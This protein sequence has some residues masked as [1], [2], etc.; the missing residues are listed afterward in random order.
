MAEPGAVAGAETQA[1][2][3]MRVEERQDR[4]VAILGPGP[5][6]A[7]LV[8]GD[9][10]LAG[11]AGRALRQHDLGRKRLAAAPDAQQEACRLQRKGPLAGRPHP[12]GRRPRHD[13][14]QI[15]RQAGRP[16]LRSS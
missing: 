9:L 14:G 8:V 4:E 11:R 6:P 12:R 5:D 2:A 7:Q 3:R 10:E 13:D 16:R 1:A 15:L